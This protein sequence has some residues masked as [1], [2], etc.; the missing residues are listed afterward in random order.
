MKSFTSG[1]NSG[2]ADS[3]DEAKAAGGAG[4]DCSSCSEMLR[5]S[6]VRVAFPSAER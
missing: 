5:Y 4:G 6:I 2:V 1:L 3:L